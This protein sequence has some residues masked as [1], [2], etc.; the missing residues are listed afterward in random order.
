M[1]A[2]VVVRDTALQRHA[3]ACRHRTTTWEGL[4]YVV[5]AYQAYIYETIY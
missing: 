5:V 3:A 4:M 1:T 2:V